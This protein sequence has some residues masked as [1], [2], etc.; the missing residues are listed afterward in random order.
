MI[1]LK[2][3]TVFVYDLSGLFVYIAAALVKWYGKVYYYCPNV[4]AA[5]LL[6]DRDQMGTGIPGVIRVCDFWSYV[7]TAPSKTDIDLFVFPDVGC[8]SLQKHL[9]S[10]G[11]RVYGSK[12]SELLEV[13]KWML[14][15]TIEKTGLPFIPTVL[16]H[17]FDEL[18][19]KM[20]AEKDKYVKVA[21]KHRGAF[22]T[23][24]HVTWEDSEPWF[25]KQ[26]AKLGKYADEIE[27]LW[28]DCCPSACE[29]GYDGWQ[30]NGELVHYGMMGIECKDEGWA[31]KVFELPCEAVLKV[32]KKLLPI[33]KKLGYNGGY[34]N[35]IRIGKDGKSYYLDATC[36]T[37][38]PPGEVLVELYENY[39]E[40]VWLVGSGKMPNPKP[41]YKYAAHIILCSPELYDTWL[42]VS[43]PTNIQQY[44]KLANYCIKDGSYYCI[45]DGSGETDTVGAVIGFGNTMDEACK[46]ALGNA[47]Q[48]KAYRMSYNSNIFGDIE[49]SIK[50]A[51]A[52]GINY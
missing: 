37:G 27:M 26:R 43:F 11:Y 46:H 15:K 21:R 25:N 1:N 2:D 41:K 49:E 36:R 31:G 28:Q 32:E 48:V 14:Q 39:G 7:H 9:A 10:L 12:G 44:V 3:K 18:Q 23:F 8:G 50:T 16:I 51:K 5:Y 22:E 42:K 19:K 34:S 35:E 20:K 24:H 30:V 13:D 6:P 38:R 4:E 47:A 29:I 40:I 17:G 45:P 52:N 33:W